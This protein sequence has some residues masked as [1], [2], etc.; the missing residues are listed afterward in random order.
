[1]ANEPHMAGITSSFVETPRLK[2]HLLTSGSAEGVPV[3]FLHG[4]VSSNVFWE[5]SLL[6]LPDIYC[7][8]APDLRGYGE[9]EALPID[10]MRGPRDWADDLAALVDALKLGK[11]HL[12]AWSLGAGVAMQY[13][14]DHPDTLL[15]LTFESPVSPFGFGGTRDNEG[16]PTFADF[17]ASGGGTVNPTFLANMVAGD[18]DGD[19]PVSPR[20]TMN[21]FY[22]KPP[23][24]TTPEREEAYVS[25]MLS[26]RTGDGFYPG[27]LTASENWPGVGP[28]VSGINNALS[29]KYFQL[30]GFANIEPK[31][32]VLWIRGADDQIV[33]DTSLFDFGFLG[34]IGAVPGWPGAEVFPPQPMVSQMRHVLDAYKAGGGTYEEVLLEDCGHSPHIE[35]PG[36]YLTALIEHLR[37]ASR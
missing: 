37:Q 28:G 20:G 9:T 30:S 7:G 2:I 33:S 15:S 21:T 29:P 32:P 16:T 14:I 24:R 25:S 4:N 13:A 5:E 18:R 31:V 35:K 22:F 10:A 12:V 26:T 23:F 1:M 17:A 34:Q 11:F 3:V 19:T 6:A 27:D 8:I 36:N